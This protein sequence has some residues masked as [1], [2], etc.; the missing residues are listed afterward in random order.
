VDCKYYLPII[1][2]FNIVD[3]N[4]LFLHIPGLKIVQVKIPRNVVDDFGALTT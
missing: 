4:V 1:L 2:K 3:K